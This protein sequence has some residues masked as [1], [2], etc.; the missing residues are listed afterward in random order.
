M[1]DASFVT[2]V[3]IGATLTLAI[4]LAVVYLAGRA[5]AA[6]RHVVL[7]AAFGVLF[8]LPLATVIT[9]AIAVPVS[10]PSTPV[11]RPVVD[12]TLR[13]VTPSETGAASAA[14]S[15][16]PRSAAWRQIPLGVLWALGAG[17]SLLPF[18]IGL[19]EMRLL[20]RS[21]TP[22]ATDAALLVSLKRELGIAR[23][24][25][26]LIHKDV[27]GPMTCGIA[28]PA[29][30]L[31]H[32]VERWDARDL[33]R[34]LVHELEHVRRRDW[35]SQCVTRAICAVY[36]FHPLAWIARRQLCLEAECAF[37]LSELRL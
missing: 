14:A 1:I 36:W 19:R 34:A 37:Y 23:R 7:L 27:D 29:I 28:S 11:L 35:L 18:F 4:A 25:D 16:T 3:L 31:P 33:E 13:L 12:A 8:F 9:P 10:V 2:S 15:G 32:D 24:V 6:L 17:G 21:A 20:R 5:R 22:W 30:V 26:I